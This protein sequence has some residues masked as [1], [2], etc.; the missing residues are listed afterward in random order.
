MHRQHLLGSLEHLIAH[1]VL[2]GRIDS[3][4]E[5]AT[6]YAQVRDDGLTTPELFAA[7]GRAS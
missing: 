6:K 3:A 5:W 2:R 4:R 7:M 1:D